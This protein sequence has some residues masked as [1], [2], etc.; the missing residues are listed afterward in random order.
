MKIWKR[1][2]LLIVAGLTCAYAHAQEHRIEADIIFRQSQSVID[3]DFA[4]NTEQLAKITHLL[5]SMR[6]D[7]RIEI[8][9]IEFCGAASPEGSSTINKR[10]SNARLKALENFVRSHADEEIPEE[11]IIRNDHYIPWATLAEQVAESD[12]WYK[13]EVLEIINTPVGE[14][15]DA[16]GNPVDGR[17]PLLREIED[18]AAW[19]EMFQ[20]YFAE[21]RN[22]YMVMVTYVRHP[23]VTT[24]SIAL[25]E[26]RPFPPTDIVTEYPA[27]TKPYPRHLYIKTN[28]IGW[29][30]AVTNV[31]VEA[32]FA[33]K[34]SFQLPI[35]YSAYN[36][37]TSTIK[38]RTFTIQPEIRYWFADN[39]NDKF[40]LGAHFGLSY[41][42]FAIEGKYRIQDKDGETPALGGGLSV[43]YRM[44]ISKNGRWKMEFSLG[45]GVY[46]LKYDKFFN[47]DRTSDGELSHTINKTWFGL[48]HAAVSFSYMFNL[49][50]K[51]R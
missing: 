47:T 26:Q 21:M 40:F 39:V 28:G 18:G 35:Y 25:H 29:L 32:D 22:A 41:Y 19:R 30:M 45:A 7:E 1:I 5:D 20:L 12:A 44:P 23:N 2:I 48:D 36:Y 46:T 11:L 42:N 3:K 37:F 4:N 51:N 49:N 24:R 17:I 14:T 8:R 31:A 33:K 38:F 15:T 34:W 10:L 6:H 9:S 13:D 16:A 43:G 50:K 27:P